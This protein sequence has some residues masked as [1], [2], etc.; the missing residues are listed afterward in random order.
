MGISQ[1][2]SGALAPPAHVGSFRV[3][4]DPTR[5]I[6]GE[7]LGDKTGAHRR[8]SVMLHGLSQPERMGRFVWVVRLPGSRIGLED[9]EGVT[10]RILTHS[11][12]SHTR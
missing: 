4:R 9:R 8:K 12:P 11:E 6:I 1:Q 7:K 3:R 10:L 5:R 2:L